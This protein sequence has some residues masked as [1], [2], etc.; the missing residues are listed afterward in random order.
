MLYCNVV[1][2][3]PIL[4][5]KI[6]VLINRVGHHIK[7]RKF[8]L[9]DELI[10]THQETQN[11]V[12]VTNYNILE[13]L[14]GEEITAAGYEKL[15]ILDQQREDLPFQDIPV[16]TEFIST[17]KFLMPFIEYISTIALNFYDRQPHIPIDVKRLRKNK[18]YPV[19][20]Y[21]K[22]G[23]SKLVRLYNKG[24]VL[25]ETELIKIESRGFDYLFINNQEL[26]KYTDYVN[27]QAFEEIEK[28][29]ESLESA[30]AV[31]TVK[32]LSGIISDLGISSDVVEMCDRVHKSLEKSYEDDK[33]LNALLFKF[34]KMEGHFAYKHSYLTAVL[35]LAVGNKFS[36]MNTEIKRNIFLGSILHDVGYKNNDNALLEHLPKSSI[37]S[38]SQEQK[39]DILNHTK[40]LVQVLDKNPDIHQDVIKIVKDHHAVLGQE[41]SYPHIIP[42]AEVSLPFAI[43][44]LCHELSTELHHCEFDKSKINEIL[45]K[46]SN[47]FTSVAYKKILPA[48]MEEVTI[49]LA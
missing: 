32:D 47:K 30:A 49:I 23:A 11:H 13:K 39:S 44:I 46:I 41:N 38:L 8:H 35:A 29:S 43:F 6:S 24:T 15:L 36:W 33:F 7:I 21:I 20:F 42:A 5:G 31:E 18:S 3:D 22:L 16:T 45:D 14:N 27:G 10:T 9:A 37:E 48:F 12:L 40:R 34:R 25:D 2:D 1:L 28:N 19:D 4:S 17:N 26:N